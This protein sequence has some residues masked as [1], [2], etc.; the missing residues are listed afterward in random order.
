MA[1]EKVTLTL[2]AARLAELRRLVGARRLSAAVDQAVAAHLDRVRHLAA[3]DDW[4]VDMEREH[5]PVPPATL[6]WA[7]MLVDEWDAGRARRP[8]RAG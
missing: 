3:V 7:A 5:G 6:E 2:S 4:L 1:R 8:R